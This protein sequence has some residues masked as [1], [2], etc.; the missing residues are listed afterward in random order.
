MLSS[1]ENHCEVGS[2]G[3][4]RLHQRLRLT[5]TGWIGQGRTKC[6]EDWI[7]VARREPLP[8]SVKY[9]SAGTLPF[10]AHS[11]FSAGRS[12]LSLHLGCGQSAALFTVIAPRSQCPNHGGLARSFRARPAALV[13]L[14][15]NESG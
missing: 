4:K 15:G 3:G 10:R 1:P 5:D 9:C 7:E 11:R 13:Q 2:T 12:R 8:D 14:D 6:S